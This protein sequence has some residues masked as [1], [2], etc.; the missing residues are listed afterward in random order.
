VAGACTARAREAGLT[1]ACVQEFGSKTALAQRI[2]LAAA[3]INQTSIN[4][5]DG[6][7]DAV[8]RLLSPARAPGT[9]G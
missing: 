4:P 5:S 3:G 8:V 2:S 7:Y 6:Q 9:A 1:R